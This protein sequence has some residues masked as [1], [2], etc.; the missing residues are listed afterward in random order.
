MIKLWT[1]CNHRRSGTFDAGWTIPLWVIKS[2]T[3]LEA[4]YDWGMG[5]RRGSQMSTEHVVSYVPIHLITALIKSRSYLEGDITTLH[6]LQF[7]PDE[8]LLWF[9]YR[10]KFVRSSCEYTHSWLYN[11]HSQEEIPTLEDCCYVYQISK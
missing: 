7:N 3:L 8:D 4:K 9:G 2:C 5:T 1:I 11:T 6:K 10:T